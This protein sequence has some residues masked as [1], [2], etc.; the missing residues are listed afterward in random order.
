MN[1]N[2]MKLSNVAQFIRGVTFEKSVQESVLNDSNLPLLRAGNIQTE[3]DTKNDLIYVPISAVSKEQILQNGDIVICLSSG[4]SQVV[5]KSAPLEQD[6]RGTVGGFCGIVRPKNNINAEYLAYWMRSPSFIEWRDEQAR[7]ANIQNLRFSEL[8]IL[9]IAVPCANKQRHIAAKLKAQLAAVEEA[10]QAAQ[11]QIDEFTNLANAVIRE[12]LNHPEMEIVSL[13]DVLNEVKQ[14]IGKGWANYPV[15]GATR[16]GLAPAKEPVGKNPERY[17]PVFHG[18][19]FYNPMRILIGSI[20]MVDADDEPGITSP[21]YVAIRGRE[22]LVDSRWF[23]YWLRSPA[24]EHCITSLARGAV[25]E[26]MLF[27]RLAE[28]VAAFPPFAVQQKASRIL[29][30]IRPMKTHV[31]AQLREIERLPARL[32]AEAFGES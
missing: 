29:T 20:A 7:G 8:G 16:S 21:D 32:L 1:W 17:K 19:V 9:E 31:E 18:T 12:S 22:G 26:R 5:G 25:R 13:G 6:W 3:L 10:R 24:G 30:E 2:L 4:S 27:N 15:L 11:Q 23:Y 28:G 14:G